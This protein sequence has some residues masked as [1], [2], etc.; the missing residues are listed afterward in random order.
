MVEKANQSKLTDWT[1]K[2]ITV[3]SSHGPYDWTEL[4][5]AMNDDPT[6]YPTGMVWMRYESPAASLPSTGKSSLIVLIVI[7]GVTVAVVAI[8]LIPSRGKRQ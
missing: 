3:D 4:A 2:I 8:S 6:A 1:G 5:S 7:V